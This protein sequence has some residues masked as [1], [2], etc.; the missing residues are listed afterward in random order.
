MAFCSNCKKKAAYEVENVGAVVQHF[1][2]EHL[3]HIFNKV[4]LPP[5]VKTIVEEIKAEV[6]A[7]IKKEPKAK[8]KKAE[9]PV[10]EEAVVEGPV[11]EADNAD[12]TDSN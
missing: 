4:H 1:C 10:V 6:K 12:S 2:D 9:E 11:V 8:T 7:E 3:P 5:H